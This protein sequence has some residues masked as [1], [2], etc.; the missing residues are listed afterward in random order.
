MNPELEKLIELQQADR[1]VGRLQEEIAALPRRVAA[2]EAKLAGTKTRVEAARAA[3][4]ADEAN[5]RKY[6]TQISDL[7]QKISKY[8][9]QSLDVKTNEQY[10]ALMN[11]I[12]FAERDIGGLED[13]ILEIMVG[14][15]LREQEIKELD[16]ELKAE[17]AEID[18][19][20]QEARRRTA[21]DQAQ[22]ATWNARRQELRSGIEEHVLRHYERV[23]KFRGSA[24]TEVIGHKCATCQVM[25]R[26]QVYNEVRTNEQIVT[27]DSCQRI[28]YFIP[29]HQPPEEPDLTVTRGR[30]APSKA[31]YFLPDYRGGV[32]A[33]AAFVT[34]KGNSSMR[35]Y[36]AE[37]GQKLD[38]TAVEP[39]DFKAAFSQ[40]VREGTRIRA[41]LHEDHLEEWG[42]YLPGAELSDLHAALH[43]A[44]TAEAEAAARQQA[45]AGEP[46]GAEEE[47]AEESTPQ[48]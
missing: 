48:P 20:K 43:E 15:E 24:V 6:E 47:E 10:R 33:F 22:L 34:G 36:D 23:M 45:A 13:K 18:R 26:P 4:K 1:E 28:L 16:A 38:P 41:A 11:E 42:E 8:R 27:C 32:A 44:Q 5:R 29:E 17:T 14:A 30:K 12:Q 2:I 25:L 46:E 21:E 37:T 39:G 3:V 19:E 9:D 35:V 7:R 31:W 40:Y